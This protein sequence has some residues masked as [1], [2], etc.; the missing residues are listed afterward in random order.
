MMLTHMH[1]R[2]H[3][4]TH[5]RT[6]VRTHTHTKYTYYIG[7]HGTKTHRVRTHAHTHTHT[8]THTHANTQTHTHANT[9][10]HIQSARLCMHT[11]QLVQL[12]PL[13]AFCSCSNATFVATYK[14]ASIFMA[15]AGPC[16]P[17]RGQIRAC[18]GPERARFQ[19]M[20]MHV[21]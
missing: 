14:S 2:T 3:V 8:H 12:F 10:T 7:T 19:S 4:R 1:T 6:H 18:M 11:A 9:Q 13:L 20:R 17:I 15:R 16:K 21:A 5:A